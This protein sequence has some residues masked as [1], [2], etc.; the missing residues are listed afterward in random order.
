MA[1]QAGFFAGGL[2]I[3]AG[4][5]WLAAKRE[6]KPQLVQGGAPA[7]ASAAVGAAP[8]VAGPTVVTPAATL[9]AAAPVPASASASA[10]APA[11]GAVPAAPSAGAP[12]T[13]AVA[14]P[15]QVTVA[16]V[17]DALAH[18]GTPSPTT[19]ILAHE[20]YVSAYDR[21]LRH[22]VW[23]AEHLTAESLQRRDGA[24][25]ANSIFTEDLRIPD[26]F[27]S[28]N[29]AYFRSGYDRGHMVPAADAKAT[30]NAMNETFL[31]TNIA[32]QVGEG[33]NR[34]Y[35]AHTE[36]FCR[37]LTRTFSDVY[38][39]TVPLYLPRQGADGKWRVSYEVIGT[40]PSVS[41]PTHFAKVILGVN[42]AV[43]LGRAK[44]F[45][46]GAFV[47]PNSMIP[48][49]APLRSFEMDVGAVERA[50]G[51]DAQAVRLGHV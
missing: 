42:N 7:G 27:R 22:P 36:D 39:F 14:G 4:G 31:L 23:T 46:M 21:R 25:R 28:T 12:A 41:V 11:P 40:P 48:N 30:Q 34:D 18:S 45:S 49:S 24:N 50:A 29:A 8:A 13:H 51:V 5:A 17:H 32:P 35:W 47:I 20:A 10:P 44:S 16:A 38:I 33:M 3:G 37:R 9:S 43:G 15:A 26:A 2:I 19:D 6:S 1:A